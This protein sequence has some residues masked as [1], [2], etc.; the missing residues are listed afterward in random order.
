MRR[1]RRLLLLLPLPSS[2]KNFIF[3]E[4]CANIQATRA[5]AAVREAE[6]EAAA[7]AA[8]AALLVKLLDFSL[9]FSRYIYIFFFAAAQ[10]K[11]LKKL[12]EFLL[13]SVSSGYYDVVV[14][15][16]VCLWRKTPHMCQLTL[17]HPTTH[18]HRERDRE[19]GRVRGSE[20]S[21]LGAVTRRQRR[22]R[23]AFWLLTLTLT[24]TQTSTLALDFEQQLLILILIFCMRIFMGATCGANMLTP[25]A[26]L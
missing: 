19:S 23:R 12:K 16:C 11:K 7:T 10:K 26:C 8:E 2:R 18:N 3:S 17:I 24:L 20:K 22:Q 9:I 13:K 15:V 14:C 25:L 4:G 6:A 21:Q 5:A 1:C